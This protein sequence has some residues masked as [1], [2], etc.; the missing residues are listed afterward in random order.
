M[1]ADLDGHIESLRN[2]QLRRV[3][4]EELAHDLRMIAFNPLIPQ[5]PQFAD[6]LMEISLDFRRHVLRWAK[7]TP[8]NKD[9]IG[10]VRDIRER[11][12]QLLAKYAPRPS[13]T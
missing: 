6:G 9:A 13:A 8:K 11:L 7:A 2:G 3:D 12:S 1:P 10:A 5:Q 4:L